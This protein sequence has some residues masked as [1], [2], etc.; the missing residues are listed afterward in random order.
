MVAMAAILV[1]SPAAFRTAFYETYLHVHIA[2]VALVLAAWWI[3]IDGMQQM[4]YLQA[5]IAIWVAER[6]LRLI[7]LIYRNL[8]RT[9]TRTHAEVEALPGDAM[10]ITI[11]LA[12][13]VTLKPGQ[14]IFF[15]LPPVGLWTDHPFSLAWSETTT[16]PASYDLEKG[17]KTPQITFDVLALPQTTVSLII[18]RRGGFTGCL[19]KKCE[20]SHNARISLPAFVEGPYG[21][22]Q[23]LHSYG[24]VMLFAGGV[25]ITHQITSVRDLTAGY[26]SSTAAAQRVTLIWVIRSSEHLE[27]IRPWMTT[28]LSMPK[29]RNLLRIQLFV[30]R[31]R[32]TKEIH[33]PGNTVQ[34][35]P[36]KPNVDTLC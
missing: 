27:W 5:V 31:P 16:T 36:G 22:S 1:L 2:L 33:S 29:R 12:R 23:V 14:H 21:G 19:Y 8:A 10:R 20:A 15:T 26:V 7:S 28:M 4:P 17:S 9:R 25:G 11:R 6:A 30:T 35:Y 13:P 18:R 34:M 3:H 32:S 24:T